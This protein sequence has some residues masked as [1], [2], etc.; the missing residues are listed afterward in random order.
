M[1]IKAFV[2]GAALPGAH[3]W[4]G[5]RMFELRLDMACRDGRQCFIDISLGKIVQQT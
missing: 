1:K 3:T 4:K 5:V 2:F